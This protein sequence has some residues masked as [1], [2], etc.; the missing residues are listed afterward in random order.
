MNPFIFMVARAFSARAPIKQRYRNHE[1][2][3]ET[4]LST[5]IKDVEAAVEDYFRTLYEKLG[6]QIRP[7][8]LLP[9]SSAKSLGGLEFEA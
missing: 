1:A 6:I 3:V 4:I 8:L 2:Y 7:G 9:N 5:P